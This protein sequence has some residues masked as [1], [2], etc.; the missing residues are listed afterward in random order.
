[1]NA[2]ELATFVFGVDSAAVLAARY[3]SGALVA[4]IDRGIDGAPKYTLTQQE[5]EK[6]MAQIAANEKSGT[7]GEKRRTKTRSS[8]ERQGG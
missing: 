3:E 5:T 2:K 7:T 1:M 4:V 8:R 6:A